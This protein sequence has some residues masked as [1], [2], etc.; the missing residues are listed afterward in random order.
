MS[1]GIPKETLPNERRVA[2]VPA[3]VET[4]VKRGFTV[5]VEEGAGLEASFAN[6]D[7]E[8]AGA[9]VT[10][11]ANVYKS[12]ILLKVLRINLLFYV[13]ISLALCL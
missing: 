6:K 13:I 10:N 8:A 4:L 1:I 2:I 12:N 11:A 7:Y 5:S 3:A 9:K